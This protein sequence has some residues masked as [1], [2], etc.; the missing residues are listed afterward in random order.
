MEP[1][2]RVHTSFQPAHA[3]LSQ[4]VCIIEHAAVLCQFTSC[5]APNPAHTEG[6]FRSRLVSAALL[7]HA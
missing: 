1:C 2:C 6:R 5:L 4:R 3:A 7:S